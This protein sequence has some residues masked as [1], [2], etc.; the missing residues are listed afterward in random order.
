MAI[1]GGPNIVTD[2]LVLHLD[3]ANTKSYPGS[4]NVWYDLSGNYN[5]GNLSN[6]N[7]NSAN[8][9][10]LIFNGT[11]STCLLSSSLN[12]RTLACP[13]TITAWA[14]QNTSGIRTIFAQYTSTTNYRLTKLLRIDNSIM[15]Y[16]YGLNNGGF[17]QIARTGIQFNRWN[18]FSVTVR[19]SPSSAYLQLGYNLSY[20]SL[21]FRND[22]T[23]TPDT[24]VPI[25]IGSNAGFG[26]DWD[27]SIANVSVYNKALSTTE[28]LQ[29]YNATKGRFVL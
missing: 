17:T 9:G 21:V 18:Y 10:A 4:G 5:N 15:Y 1:Y 29:N 28:L 13:L 8:R 12:L 3:A 16:Y 22:L 11:T 23:T 19:G 6:C 24:S 7:F 25:T 26:E 14:Y 2:G 27:G 20:T